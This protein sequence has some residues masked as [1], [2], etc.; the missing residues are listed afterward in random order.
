VLIALAGDASNMFS[1]ILIIHF[2][3]FDVILFM[4]NLTGATLALPNIRPSI[5]PLS[6]ASLRCVE[7]M[8]ADS[9]PLCPVFESNIRPVV[10][11]NSTAS[12]SN[13]SRDHATPLV[14]IA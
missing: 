13:A 7:L 11:Q 6:R 4:K 3:N 8:L 5:V 10:V 14:P 1:S 2:F 9:G 12:N